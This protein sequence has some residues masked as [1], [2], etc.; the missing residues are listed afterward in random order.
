MIYI[1]EATKEQ[2]QKIAD[3]TF[4]Y[5]KSMLDSNQKSRKIYINKI[6]K[7]NPECYYAYFRIVD[8]TASLL[9]E[10][11]TTRPFYASVM[12]QF[13]LHHGFLSQ[14]RELKFSKKGRVSNV[15]LL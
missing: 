15:W 10:L 13:L 1:D 3:F 14:D 6:I 7:K 9:K 12:F 2:K 11:D 5:N 4:K 8:E